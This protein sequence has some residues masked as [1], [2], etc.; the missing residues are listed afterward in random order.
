[1]GKEQIL[2]LIHALVDNDEI[3][4]AYLEHYDVHSDRIV[5]EN[6]NTP[7]TRAE[8]C[9][10]MMAIKW[11]DPLFFPSSILMGELH[12]D[13]GGPTVIDHDV[14]SDLTV[15]TAEKVKDKWWGLLHGL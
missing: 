6:Q 12:S 8:C 4:H 10:A 11:K 2:L 5:I 9:W 7:E 13:F 15:A 14:I 3:K 1:M